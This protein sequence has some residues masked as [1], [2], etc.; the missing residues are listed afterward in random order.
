M[1]LSVGYTFEPGLI[2]SLAAFPSVREVYG[3]LDRDIIGGGRSTYT[4]RRTS[5]TMVKEAVK[6]AHHYGME[7]NY[8]INAAW[9]GGLE[10]TRSGQEKIRKLLDFIVSCNADSVT[11]ASPYLARLIKAQY[12]QLKVRVSVFAVVDNPLKAQQWEKMGVDTICV[13]GIACN[14]DFKRLRAIRKAVSC[15][16]QLIVNA[17]CIAGCTHELT[18]MQMLSQSSR[19]GD[20]LKGFVL[21]YCFLNCSSQRFRDPVNFIRSIWIRPEDLHYYEDMGYDSFKIVERSSPKELVIKRVT[22]Y[23][24]RS[25]AGNLWEL[26]APVAHISS[27]QRAPLQQR[28]RVITHLFKP[29]LVKPRSLALLKKYADKLM[30]NSWMLPDAPVYIDNRAL[31]GFIEGIRKRDC[32]HLECT[33]CGFCRKWAEKTV[34]IE[35]RYRSDV[36]AMADKLDYG[37]EH[38]AHWL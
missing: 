8:L 31:N 26:I 38:S 19:K 18:H 24:K 36:L 37:L 12:P 11:V 9:L 32:S 34:T 35:P 20:P 28:L 29:H 23:E 1:E 25:F 2:R 4:L 15:R 14:R 5:E 3:K 13:S 30:I 22:A 10:Q 7:F 6:E 21:D 33:Q 16:L 17:S 27:Q